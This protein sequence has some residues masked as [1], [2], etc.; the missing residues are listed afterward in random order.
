MAGF[1]SPV[2]IFLLLEATIEAVICEKAF[3]GGAIVVGVAI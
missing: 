3:F 1:M 2:V